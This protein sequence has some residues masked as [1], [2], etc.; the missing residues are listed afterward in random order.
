MIKLKNGYTLKFIPMGAES[1]ME[2][3]MGGEIAVDEAS[4]TM[5]GWELFAATY[6]TDSI[7]KACES[8]RTP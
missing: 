7:I 2:N 3:H 4:K 8:Y 5:Y 6:G 1:P